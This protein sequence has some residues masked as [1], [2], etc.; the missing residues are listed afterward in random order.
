[1]QKPNPVIPHAPAWSPLRSS[2][3]RLYRNEP[4]NTPQT[5]TAAWPFKRNPRHVSLVP[6]LGSVSYHLVP[7]YQI[8]MSALMASSSPALSRGFARNVLAVV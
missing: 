7:L 2:F 6:R 3:F 1:M 4:R 8:P 5:T